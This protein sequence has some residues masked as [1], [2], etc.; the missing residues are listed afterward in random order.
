MPQRRYI[1]TTLVVACIL[2]AGFVVSRELADPM[3]GHVAL[4]AAGLFALAIVRSSVLRPLLVT[5]R[6]RAYGAARGYETLI[7]KHGEPR[8]V[9]DEAGLGFIAAQSTSL[10]GGGGGYYA[11]TVVTA[12]IE[13]DVPDGLRIYRR[14]ALEWMH[15]LSGLREVETG[16]DALDQHLMIE[17]SDAALTRAWIASRRG[18]LDDVANKYPRFIAYGAEIDGIPAAM[19]G[20][21]G[22]ITLIV[23]GRRSREDELAELIGDACRYARE[24]Q[25]G[26]DR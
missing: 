19:G 26:A 10:L 2:G 8:M 15:Q 5:R 22:A 9:G 25:N 23:V 21:S 14:D 16:D 18:V 1:L 20:A 17:G 11:R 7:G 12:T 3:A 6:W 13:G 24:L 4:A